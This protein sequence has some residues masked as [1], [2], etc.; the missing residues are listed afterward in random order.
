MIEIDGSYLEGGGQIIRTS[1]AL[2]AITGKPCKI[3]NIRSGRKN[4][5]L[6]A[7]HLKGID[8]AA[9]LCDAETKG[10]TLGS[11]EVEFYPKKIKGGKFS[12]DIGT[13][14][15]ITLVL[16]TLVPICLF[17]ESESELE[18]TGGTDVSWSP[19]TTY[20]QHIF[21]DFL[22]RM[23]VQIKVD[24]TKYGFYPKGGGN[25]KVSIIPNRKLMP[26]NLVERGKLE[27]VDI[28]SIASDFLKRAN[29]AERQV[30][31]AKKIYAS[32]GKTNI[33]YVEALSPGSSVHIHSHYG[34][35]KIGATMLGEIGRPAEKVGEDCAVLLEDQVDSDG[36]L[37]EWMADQI[38]PY[39]AFTGESKVSVAEITD[40]CLTNIWVI[41]KFLHVKFE[42]KENI[43]SCSTLR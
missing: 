8:A 4:P 10:L 11:Q 23:G 40:H 15:S 19:N 17:A 37:D 35:C 18:I 20:F 3:T 43:I 24:T 38:L 22:E 25:V 30:D 14:G 39:M 41:E 6:Q 7:Q 26:L 9:K 1:I 31:G 34:N 13:A 27:R 32:F 12:I 21:C 29:V 5:G 33:I 16:Q 42:I 28:W 2:S 36:C